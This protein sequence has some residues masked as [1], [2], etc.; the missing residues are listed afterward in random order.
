MRN[1]GAIWTLAIALAL[2]CVY[3]LW[4][5]VK[6]Y[7]VRNDAVKYAQG[8]PVLRQQYLDS[9]SGEVVYNFFGLRKY[10]YKECLERE[11][12]LGLDLQGGMNVILEVSAEDV[13]RALANNSKDTTFNKAIARAKELQQE[14]EGNFVDLF[15]RAWKEI[16]SDAQMAANVFMT[17]QLREKIN[18]NSTND[19]VLEVIK[20]ETESA[21]NNSFNIIRTRIDHFGVAQPNVQRI[22]GGERILVELP[23]VKDKA[24]VEKLLQGTAR[25]EFWETYNNL[26]IYNNL[27][28]ANKV[29]KQ[30]LDAEKELEKEKLAAEESRETNTE[31]GLLQEVEEN[32]ESPA[33]IEDTSELSLI[34]QL[35][36]DTSAIDSLSEA[37]MYENFPL[38][39][40]LSPYAT[41]NELIPGSRIGRAH[42]RDTAK[43]NRLMRIALQRG[44]FPKDFKYFWSAIPVEDPETEKLTDIYDMH[45]IRITGRDGKAPLDGDVIVSARDGFDQYSGTANVSMNMNG[46]GT[47]KWALIT[48]NNV[49][50]EII[51]AMD[52]LVYSAAVV[53]EEI[54]AGSTEISGNFTPKEAQDLANLL[55]SG[56]LPARCKIIQEEVIGPSLGRQ[57]VKSG[58]NSFLV[59]FMVILLYMV[60]YYSRRA[61]MVADIALLANM[62]FLIGVLASLGPALTLPGI[63]GIVLTIGMSV[64]A[65]VLIFERIREE[66]A[67]GKGIRMA[68]ADGYRNAYSAIIDGN[69]TTLITGVILFVLGTGPIKGFATTLVIGILT[70][71]FS[72]IFIT[73]LVFEAFLDRNKTLTFSTPFTEGAFKNTKINFI[74]LRKTF[75]VVSGLVLLVALGSLFTRGLDQGVDFVGGR[76]YIIKFEQSVKPAEISGLLENTLQER[77]KVITFGSDDQIRITTRYRIEDDSETVEDEIQQTIY[78]ALRPVLG[79][80]VTFDQFNDTYWRSSQKVG[81]TIADDIKRQAVVALL[82]SLVFMFLYIFLRFRNWQY[83]LGAV[84]ALLHDTLIVLGVFSLLYGLMPFSLEIDQSFIAAILTVVGY[85]VN[86]TVIVFDRIREYR[87]LHPKMERSVMMNLALNSTLS[88][89]INTSL[90]TLV[91]LLT[92]FIFGGESIQGFVFAMLIGI[93]VGTYSSLFVATPVV[94]DTLKRITKKG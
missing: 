12:N 60:F 53:R 45:A 78:T 52:D 42:Y 28:E 47:K 84:A 38:F 39:A 89:T 34:S 22:E 59:A 67:G 88:R 93:G 36:S 75:Y 51:V 43:V 70:S 35:E 16:N 61:G 83:G 69:L 33:N 40:V 3:Q 82:V 74:G 23:G 81:P 92:I 71:L 11:I 64:D 63:A 18:Y 25:L 24:R 17:P 56:T 80:D 32:T 31:S 50:K 48:Q 58:F 46:E 41:A 54:T 30:Y 44:V 65:N 1:K 79:D 62:F 85:S 5:T 68:I 10:T 27:I 90:T 21:V 94:Y 9:I 20:E 26:E 73:R 72:A 29:I 86:D 6:T 8:D 49:G 4:F 76:N 91:V 2:V 55:K 13:V 66:V 57:S 14:V 87:K 77:P 15:G 7:Q 37:S 19:E